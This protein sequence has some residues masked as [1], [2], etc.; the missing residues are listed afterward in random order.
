M[1]WR[2]G[3]RKL[4][5]WIVAAAL[6]LAYAHVL[7]MLCLCISIGVATLAWRL[8]REVGVQKWLRGLIM[9]P[10]PIL[11]GALYC[12]VV[13]L[14]HRVAPHIYWE[15][16]KD[17]TDVQA[18]S[19][20]WDVSIFAVNNL[21][22]QLDRALFILALA[23][24]A[25]L[26]ITSLF[27]PSPP[28]ADPREQAAPSSD[29]R[30]EF[31]ALAGVWFLLYL[32]TPRVLMSTW[33]IFERLPIWWFLFLLAITPRLAD[34]VVAWIRL[35]A[36]GV[37][38]VA[39]LITAQAFTAIPD[40]RDANAIIDDIPEGSHVVAL[41]YSYS[42]SPAIWRE[43]WVHQLAYYLV[44]RPGEIAFDFTRYASIPVRRRNAEKPPLFPSSLEWN[45]RRY[46]PHAPYGAA[47]PIVL[48]RTPDGAPNE[49][50]RERAFGFEA[51]EVRVVS[52]RGR[53]WLL[54]AS[55]L[56]R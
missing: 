7:A 40:A 29:P 3:E 12:T 56:Y 32:V 4:L 11:P 28:R 49:D 10:L 50:P 23:L 26:W 37:G 6:T 19:K 43:M 18:W 27:V 46:D 38:L 53:F 5:P 54:D 17:G 39:S 2:D 48:V 21:S 1:R 14:Y 45:A 16:Q 24:V 35:G 31:V 9:A 36:A 41:M 13:F 30:R 8:P 22:S 33:W 52:H 34:R 42:A 20:L 47:F 25:A 51:S 15:P 44:R 55:E